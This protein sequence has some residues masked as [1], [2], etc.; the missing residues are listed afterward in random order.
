LS[1]R[2]VKLLAVDLDGTLVDSAPDIAHCLG[3]ALEAVGYARPG[4][5]RTR[6][7]IGDGLETLISRALAHAGQTETP[8]AGS[9]T[10]ATAEARHRAALD[11]FLACYRDN[12]YV[13]SRLYPEAVA[14]LDDLRSRGIQLCC[15]TNKRYSFSEQLLRDAGV[16]DRFELLLGGDS[17]PEKKPSPLPLSVA[18][19]QLGV[20][21]AA[22][23]LVGDSH[24]DLRAARSAGYA[25]VL[26]SY[27]YGKIDETEL[28]DSPRIRKFAD[29]P[30]ALG[31]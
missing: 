9:P 4:E 16:L 22:A 17:L 13:R 20:P 26:A 8:V 23:A 7:W 10:F 25:F 1:R 6:V 11:A 3:S 31:L 24:Q 14:T 19:D 5:A 12:L 18:A 15:I 29:L 28:A 21:A 30:R 27:G 2:T